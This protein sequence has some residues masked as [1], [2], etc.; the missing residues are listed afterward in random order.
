MCIAEKLN[1]AITIVFQYC[2]SLFDSDENSDLDVCIETLRS[3]GLGGTHMQHDI[4]NPVVNKYITLLS[5]F[6]LLIALK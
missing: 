2:A 4:Y 1:I 6:K 3:P 5:L